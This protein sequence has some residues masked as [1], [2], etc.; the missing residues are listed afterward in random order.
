MT[1]LTNWPVWL[2]GCGD[3]VAACLSEIEE[4]SDRLIA[5]SSKGYEYSHPLQ[6]AFNSVTDKMS[7]DG[8]FV[9]GPDGET[10][11]TK[12]IGA[13][14]TA[15]RSVMIGFLNQNSAAH[16]MLGT[17]LAADRISMVK[18]LRAYLSGLREGD[19]L[20]PFIYGRCII[21]H[22]GQL[23][24]LLN[25]IQK[26][27]VPLSFEDANKM[28]GKVYK[29]IGSKVYSTRID[30][31]KL[32]NSNVTNAIANQDVK[33]R[34][35]ENRLDLEAKGLMNSIDHLDKEL[36]GVRCV[37][38]ILCEFAHPN[39]GNI[40]ACTESVDPFVD[41]DGVPWVHKRLGLLAP[42]GFVKALPE[43]IAK[44]IETE[45]AVLR[46]YN[47]LLEKGEELRAKVLK[48]TQVVVRSLVH[49]AKNN[50]NIYN[51]CPCGSGK[52]LKFCCLS[53]VTKPS[54]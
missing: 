21:E 3:S 4:I 23:H 29:T 45:T 51:N 22:T 43:A 34:P 28:L 35:S 48:L 8:L 39:V 13:R 25:D 2:T 33:Y 16:R 30:W 27:E 20:I 17:F 9:K 24:R 32:L 14:V 49:K 50:L 47:G 1:S 36:S 31:H 18:F 37:Y 42:L 53:G 26:F 38:E 54:N 11:P 12:E 7:S 15:D 19:L 52:K 6:M 44:I 10:I 5:E 40:G 41:S 46:H